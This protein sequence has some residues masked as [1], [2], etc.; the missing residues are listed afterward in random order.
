[1]PIITTRFRDIAFEE[2]LKCAPTTS[3]TR[4][5]WE[6]EMRGRPVRIETPAYGPPDSD[7]RIICG[8]PLYAYP[9][10]YR[11]G[12]CPHIAEIGD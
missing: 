11:R 9:G 4:E 2:V 8:G 6:S 3:L 5:E 12:V 10:L 1:M 7:S